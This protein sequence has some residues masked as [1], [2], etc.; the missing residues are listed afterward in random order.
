MAEYRRPPSSRLVRA[1]AISPP[2]ERPGFSNHGNFEGETVGA[3]ERGAARRGEATG[4]AGRER[5]RS[6]SATS[7]C[8][9]PSE[10]DMLLM[11]QTSLETWLQMIQQYDTQHGLQ[12]AWR[13]PPPGVT[14]D[15]FRRLGENPHDTYVVSFFEKEIPPTTLRR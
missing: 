6:P 5:A 12:P 3:R 15:A 9:I 4:G 1:A 10:F 14:M 8:S 13:V 11:E 7:Q 2:R